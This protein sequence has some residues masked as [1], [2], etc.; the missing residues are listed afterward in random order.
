MYR[1]YGSDHRPVVSMFEIDM[2]EGLSLFED[3]T[4][5]ESQCLL[6]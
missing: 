3:E 2:E 4:F 6:I 1:I 5:T